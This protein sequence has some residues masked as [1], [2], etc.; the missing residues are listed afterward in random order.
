MKTALVR[1]DN[2]NTRS[3]APSLAN[4]YASHRRQRSEATRWLDIARELARP[5]SEL[6][7]L[8]VARIEQTMR[9]LT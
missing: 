3:I 2:D 8:E 6:D 5:G 4:Y 1:E 7:T 9:E